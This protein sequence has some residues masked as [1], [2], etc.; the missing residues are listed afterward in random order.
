MGMSDKLPNLSYYD[1][2]GEGY[3]FTKPYSEDTALLIDK[4][5]QVMVNEQY[6]RAKRLLR[7]HAQG[8]NALADKLLSE[9]VIFG[10]DL[11]KI[12]GERQWVSR[13]EEILKE[14]EGE[15]KAIGQE[16][17]DNVDPPGLLAEE[18]QSD[19]E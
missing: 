19:E 8:H 4:E 18:G 17:K 9:E 5:V 7:E 3:G 1:S 2:T 16:I 11:K 6:E 14:N 13:S 15:S 12:F 10:D